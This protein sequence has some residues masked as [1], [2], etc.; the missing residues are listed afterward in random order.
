MKTQRRYKPSFQRS[1]KLW[2][3]VL[4]N[5]HRVLYSLQGFFFCEYCDGIDY[6]WYSK[7]GIF[8]ECIKKLKLREVSNL[9]K[10]IVHI[11]VREGTEFELGSLV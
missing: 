5:I 6:R 8:P 11:V 10:F 4:G 9:T 1:Y 7:F 3:V 2:R